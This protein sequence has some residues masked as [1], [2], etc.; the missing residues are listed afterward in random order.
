M[1]ARVL[2][3]VGTPSMVE[4]VTYIEDRVLPDGRIERVVRRRLIVP[5]PG[6]EEVLSVEDRAEAERDG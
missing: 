3:V 2:S 4:G 1:L 5:A 6:D